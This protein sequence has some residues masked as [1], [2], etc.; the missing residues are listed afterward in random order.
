VNHLAGLKKKWDKL[1]EG[2]K[3]TIIYIVLGFLIA[4]GFNAALGFALNT[5]TPVVAVFSESMVPTYNK[6]DM[7]IVVGDK[8]LSI[9]DVVVFD[10]P[11]RSYPI[12]HRVYN[13]TEDGKILTKGDNNR[14]VDPWKT[15]LSLVH[16]KSVLRIPLLGWVKI[17]FTKTTGLA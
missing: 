16:G 6:G 13:I 14:S 15:D 7:I 3:G 10:S 4:Y 8:N 17:I 2:W 12:I 11:A 5:D 1:T 9:G